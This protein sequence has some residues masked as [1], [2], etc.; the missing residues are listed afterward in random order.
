[1]LTLVRFTTLLTVLACAA[2]L[3]GQ[4]P[5]ASIAA[6][7]GT[8]QSAQINTTFATALQAKVLD[9]SGSPVGGITV[10]FAA[11]SSGASGTF[12]SG[13]A[14]AV[15]QT[16]ASGVAT[17]PAFRA[18]GT[19]GSYQV[20]ATVAG[21]RAP[22]VFSLSN[23]ATGP[24]TL[25]AAPN[26]LSFTAYPGLPAPPAQ[27]ISISSSPAAMAYS[28][29]VTGAPWLSVDSTNGSTPGVVHVKVDPTGLTS[30]TYSGSVVIALRTVSTNFPVSQTIQ[31]TLTVPS[32]GNLIVGPTG[33]LSFTV[34]P[35]TA[36]FTQTLQ[37]ISSN[38]VSLPFSVS[39]S[40]PE[41]TVTP[42]SAATPALV[43]LTVDPG[44]LA[45][46][47]HNTMVTFKSVQ[48]S[49]TKGVALTIQ[50]PN[51]GLNVYPALLPIQVQQG[52]SARADLEV[53]NSGGASNQS[54]AATV[55]NSQN[56]PWLTVAPPSGMLLGSGFVQVQVTA[57]ATKL[58]AGTYTS[59]IH[60]AAGTASRDTPVTVT[61]FP[62]DAVMQLNF[63]GVTLRQ[64]QGEGIGLTEAVSVL[65]LGPTPFTW[66]AE[67][68]SGSQWLAV[69]LG[70]SQT[71]S[72]TS[73]GTIKIGVRQDFA[74][75]RTT[76]T[77]TYYGSVR[78]SSA[79]ALN[80]PQL[81]TVVLYV[82]DPVLNPP[83]PKP[84]PTGLVFTVPQ[85][86]T[87]LAQTV[88]IFTSSQTPQPFQVAAQTYTGPDQDA[89]APVGWLTVTP[90]A[91]V[92]GSNNT[93][94]VNVSINSAGLVPGVYKGG[95]T[96]SMSTTEIRTDSVTLLVTP[97]STA[98][99]QNHVHPEQAGCVPTIL[100]PTFTDGL[101]NDFLSQVAGP[102]PVTVQVT[103]DCGTLV[104]D[105]NT[106]GSPQADVTITFSSGDPNA[107]TM[108]LTDPLNAGYTITWT[109]DVSAD[110][111]Q[112]TV[113][114]NLGDLSGTAGTMGASG[115][116]AAAVVSPLLL[117]GTARVSGTVLSSPGPV[118]AEHGTLSAFNSRVGALLA[119]GTIVAIYGVNL[120]ASDQPISPGVLPLPAT[121]NGTQ[122]TIGG[123]VAPLYYVSKGQLNAQI[124]AE[125]TPG[126]SYQV[127]V[128]VNS[129]LTA[130][131]EISLVA[132]TPGIA[133]T[134]DGRVIAQHSDFSLVTQSHPAAPGEVIVIYLVGMGQTNPAVASGNAA[135][136]SEPLARV[137]NPP[138]V[139]LDGTPLGSVLYAGQTP[140]SVGLYQIN[141]TVPSNTTAGDHNLA[142]SQSGPPSN[143]AILSVGK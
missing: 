6:S 75:S 50:N 35:G 31:I 39:T 133:T 10:T 128:A 38:Q 56:T 95:V 2:G 136:S 92:T 139:T 99:S 123:L 62:A 94:T 101:T 55:T 43:T 57:D 104:P 96:F 47:S 81:I 112:A 44:S 135:P 8:P 84:D 45:P 141:F 89:G 54:F 77:G 108:L 7:A 26:A 11:P 85:G 82:L 122:V 91:G 125:L 130:P 66:T 88:N 119:P 134:S 71:S 100:V 86:G 105:P 140:G 22:A 118:L 63:K 40:G 74:N 33:D 25:S 98:T 58:A 23:L 15:V 93:A 87:T 37:V 78:V 27:A 117:N 59:Q 5:A 102:T 137:T 126:R 14:S 132:T 34:Q 83:V 16:N 115:K 80:S 64:R 49:V 73:P 32:P 20:T 143:T 124:P 46:G 116:N 127:Q 106:P 68:L 18:N 114:A 17:A 61:V 129:A 103:D 138:T 97:P 131:D 70:P 111:T 19:V 3:R 142:V 109:P 4:T 24:L 113:V 53:Q 76:Q 90:T 30:K 60:I 12:A 51:P 29:S 1:M 42:S 107:K 36:P 72:P 13:A 120:A 79:Q 9:Y 65:N 121:V 69:D 67:V 41:V 52:T 48:N 21:V 28:V 110:S